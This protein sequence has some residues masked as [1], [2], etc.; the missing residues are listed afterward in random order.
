MYI[1]GSN[2]IICVENMSIQQF[3]II[4]YVSI[5]FA[6]GEGMADIGKQ[7][8]LHAEAIDDLRLRGTVMVASSSKFLLHLEQ[9]IWELFYLL[10]RAYEKHLW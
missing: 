7:I 4:C 5:I 9:V 8:E 2:V 10:H 3:I 6:L 1:I